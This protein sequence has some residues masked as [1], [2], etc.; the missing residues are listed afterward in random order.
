MTSLIKSIKHNKGDLT[1]N[2]TENALP[3]KSNLKFSIYSPSDDSLIET[4]DIDSNTPDN[5]VSFETRI[6][7]YSH[8]TIA[9][10]LNDFTDKLASQYGVKADSQTGDYWASMTGLGQRRE[11]SGSASLVSWSPAPSPTWTWTLLLWLKSR[12]RLSELACCDLNRDWFSAG[13]RPSPQAF[14]LRRSI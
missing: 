6:E 13:T 12:R 9:L 3:G 14:L 10:S 8:N 2:F 11:R 7:D 1:I 4:I 5:L